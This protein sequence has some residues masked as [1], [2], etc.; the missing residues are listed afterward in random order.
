MRILWF[1]HRDP[2]HPEAGGAEVRIREIG[3]RL[4]KMGCD[5]KLFCERW[6]GSRTFEILDGIKVFRVAG[7]YSLHLLVPF[8]LKSCGG[9]DIIVD[10]VAH[11]VPWFSPLFTRKPVIGQVHHVHE[12]VLNLELPPYLARGVI[13]LERGLK[14]IYNTFITVSESTKRELVKKFRIPEKKIFVIPNGVDLEVYRPV[15]RK[16]DAPSVI[17][18][19]RV[20]RYKRVDHVLM[21]F[22]IV[23]EKLPSARLII[24]G[25]GDYLFYLR[26]LG[27][28]LNLRDVIFTG[29]VSEAEKIR[30][31]SGAWVIVSASVVEGWALT[32]TEAA[33]CGTPCVA[34]NVPG[35]RDSVKNGET[36]L[37]AKNGNINDLADKIIKVLEDKTLRER[38]SRNALEYA[39][40]FGWDRAAEDFMRVLRRSQT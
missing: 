32:V 33:A 38:L 9:F 17:W 40:Q 24:V 13:L 37:L 18:V 2:L 34:Y 1:N 3:K 36:G 7:R 8:I 28:K 10:D 25:S 4:V 26:L 14:Y 30:L 15:C 23:K 19:G 27:K 35:L 11:A 16:F 21:T 6:G 12:S 29:R 39:K 31:M 5:V 22:K 20:K